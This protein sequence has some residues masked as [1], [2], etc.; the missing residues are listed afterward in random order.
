MERNDEVE[1]KRDEKSVEPVKVKDLDEILKYVGELGK[2]QMILI[3]MLAL[4][5]LT[6]G[7]PVLIMFFAGQ[8]PPWAC[9]QNST[10][11]NMTGSFKSGDLFYEKRCSM[12]RSEWIFTKPKEYSIVT[13]VMQCGQ[14]NHVICIALC[15]YGI[16]F[17]YQLAETRAAIYSNKF[18][19]YCMQASA[20]CLAIK[21]QDT[22]W[23]TS[24]AI[25][26]KQESC[27]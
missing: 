17:I 2:Y 3:A 22:L 8:N 14:T 19:A 7:F 11:C 6:A 5:I 20:K 24:Q 27:N 21:R 18:H 25:C 4:M 9:A 23:Q 1:L 13:Q 26:L 12:P 16:I 10:V 15:I